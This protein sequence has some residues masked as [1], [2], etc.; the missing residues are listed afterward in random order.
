M[1]VGGGLV[2]AIGWLN[3]AR[4]LRAPVMGMLRE[5]VA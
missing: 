4:L 5:A 1:I 2:A 3:A